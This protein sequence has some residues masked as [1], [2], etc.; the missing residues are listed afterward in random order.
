MIRKYAMGWCI[1]FFYFLTILLNESEGPG[2]Q[3]H[4]RC[5]IRGVRPNYRTRKSGHICRW[6]PGGCLGVVNHQFEGC[7]MFLNFFFYVNFHFSIFF[8]TRRIK[9][10]IYL[11]S[12][13]PRWSTSKYTFQS[14]GIFDQEMG[15]I[16]IT[17][18]KDYELELDKYSNGDVVMLR[19][20]RDGSPIYIAFEIE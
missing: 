3:G 20:I 7:I 2:G 4:F 17:N 10:F 8:R 15:N 18:E 9:R 1:F 19:I 6:K 13:D 12:I 5:E 16:S 14:R 11:D